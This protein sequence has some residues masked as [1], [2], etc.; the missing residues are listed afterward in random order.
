MFPVG[1]VTELG[2]SSVCVVLSRHAAEDAACVGVSGGSG[3]G[4]RSQLCVCV[5]LSRHQLLKTRRVS[6]LSGLVTSCW[7]VSVFP[8]GW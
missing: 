3:D 5:V 6:V 7:R 4:V 8:V 2:V 1:L